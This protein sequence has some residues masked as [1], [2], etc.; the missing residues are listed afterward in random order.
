[1]GNFHVWTVLNA[2]SCGPYI[3][4]ANTN[5]ILLRS[6]TEISCGVRFA[7]FRIWKIHSSVPLTPIC[8]YPSYLSFYID[9][10]FRIKHNRYAFCGVALFGEKS[11]SLP[12]QS[13]SD[14]M[15]SCPELAN[16]PFRRSH[17]HS[18]ENALYKPW[19]CFIRLIAALN[20]FWTP[21]PCYPECCSS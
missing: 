6:I 15:V 10:G 13:C 17:F 7:L 4:E 18:P 11:I 1:M 3:S 5:Y 16:H 9:Y 12:V 20:V 21:V 2:P 19:L 14:G 8:Y